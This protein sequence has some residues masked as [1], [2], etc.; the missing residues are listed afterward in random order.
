MPGMSDFHP[1]RPV[2]TSA[3]FSAWTAHGRSVPQ[4]FQPRQEGALA[5]HLPPKFAFL[6]ASKTVSAAGYPSSKWSAVTCTIEPQVPAAEHLTYARRPRG[7]TVF[8]DGS[9]FTD[10]GVGAGSGPDRYFAG[11]NDDESYLQD[12]VGLMKNQ[13]G[14]Y[15]MD[16]PTKPAPK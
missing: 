7:H 1:A 16:D 15:W 4:G 12:V 14:T 2:L 6:V 11:A 8:T 5:D 9:H 10:G 13:Q 3:Q